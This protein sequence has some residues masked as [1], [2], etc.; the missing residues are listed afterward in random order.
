MFFDN[1]THQDRTV[2][3]NT[4]R[5]LCATLI[6]VL[7]EIEPLN[8][9]VGSGL[10]GLG[11]TVQPFSLASPLADELRQGKQGHDS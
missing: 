10:A 3:F 2:E 5:S 7:G 1:A 4:I 6:V 11:P 9:G 8:Q